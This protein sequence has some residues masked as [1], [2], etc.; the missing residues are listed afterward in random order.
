MPRNPPASGADP[1][2][3]LTFG[4]DLRKTEFYPPSICQLE[5]WE[6]VFERMNLLPS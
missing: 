1:L 3:A 5:R 6:S 2:T 4:G